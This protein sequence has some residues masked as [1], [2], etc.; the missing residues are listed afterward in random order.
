MPGFD[1]SDRNDMYH[2]RIHPPK[3]RL[4]G[5]GQRQL[6]VQCIDRGVSGMLSANNARC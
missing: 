2:R 6:Q 3:L 5:Q 4:E 1:V